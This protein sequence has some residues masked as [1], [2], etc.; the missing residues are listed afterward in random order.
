MAMLIIIGIILIIVGFLVALPFF[1][2]GMFI[3]LVGDLLDIPLSGVL[4]LA[5]S[6]LLFVGGLGYFISQ[7]W[8]VIIL[9]AFLY[10]IL[11][12]AKIQFAMKRKRR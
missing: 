10:Y 12:V 11:F 1:G 6:V 5:G 4:I 2:I 3:P 9:I 7:F 8:W